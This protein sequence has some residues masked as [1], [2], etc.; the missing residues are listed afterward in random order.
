MLLGTTGIVR[1]MSEDAI[2][3]TIRAE[4]SMRA[5]LH[6]TV[7]PVVPGNYGMDFLTHEFGFDF[8]FAV[9]SSNFSYDSILMAKE[10]GFKKYFLT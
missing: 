1:P 8:G 7:L 3:Q 9:E 6:Y 5:A 2:V 4:I 10:Y